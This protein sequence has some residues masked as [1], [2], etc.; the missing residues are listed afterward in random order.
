MTHSKD[1]NYPRKEFRKIMKKSAVFFIIVL[2]IIST[3]SFAQEKNYEPLDLAMFP[4]AETGFKQVYIQVPVVENEENY[5]IELHIGKETSVDCNQHFMNGQLSEQNLEGWGYTYFK[6]ESDGAISST[7]MACLDSKLERKFITLTPQLVRY[8]SKLPVVVYIPE[9]FS[10][11][12]KIFKA[13]DALLDAKAIELKQDLPQLGRIEYQIINNYFVKNTVK[14]GQKRKIENQ[15]EFDALFGVAATMGKDG[16]PTAIDFKK[17]NVIAIIGNRTNYKT[18]YEIKGIAMGAMGV[19]VVTYKTNK[20]TK[21]TYSIR[22]F[23]AVTIDKDLTGKIIFN[24][25]K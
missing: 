19:V 13:S 3:F 17:Q 5:K 25:I 10:V 24:E 7:K 21:M 11:K 16:K 15:K 20:G 9:N 4:K 6:V 22:P 18:S 23:T 12:Y 2:L 8:N 1:A 14:K